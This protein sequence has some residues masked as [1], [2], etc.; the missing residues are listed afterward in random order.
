M[1]DYKLTAYGVHRLDKNEHIPSTVDSPY[2]TK[3]QEWLADGNTPQPADPILPNP[4]TAEELAEQMIA[5]GTMTRG[6][7]DAIKAGR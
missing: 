5:D 2:W 6:K 7:I 1:A 4:L 3:Y